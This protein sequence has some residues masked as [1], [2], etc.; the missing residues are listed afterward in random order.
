[1]TLLS[2]SGFRSADDGVESS[3]KYDLQNAVNHAAENH[4]D[5]IQLYLNDSIFDEIYTNRLVDSIKDSNLNDIVIHLPDLDDPKLERIVRRA[6]YLTNLLETDERRVRTLIHFG[7]KS[8]QSY[9]NE[10]EIPKINGRPVFIENSQIRVFDKEHVLDAV[11]LVKSLDTG[12]VFDI[13]RFAYPDNE[14][15]FDIDKYTEFVGEIMNMFEDTPDK[16]IIHTAGKSA[17]KPY[18]DVAVPHGSDNDIFKPV[19]HLLHKHHLRGGTIVFE[20]EKSDD[21]M[22]SIDYFR[23]YEGI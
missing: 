19:Y 14:G 13:G 9:G 12:L 1:M 20:A 6:N 5:G 7:I 16:L 10:V 23:N 18:R 21:V 17:P 8:D 2:H 3:E 11:K 22:A 15:A 4:Y